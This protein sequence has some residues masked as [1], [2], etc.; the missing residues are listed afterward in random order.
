VIDAKILLSQL[1]NSIAVAKIHSAN[2][3]FQHLRNGPRITNREPH[4]FIDQTSRRLD[5]T[6]APSR[7]RR[8]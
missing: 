4:S 7:C 2:S 5:V 3:M 8:E 1:S 6:T